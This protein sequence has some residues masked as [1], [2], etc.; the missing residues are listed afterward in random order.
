LSL[1]NPPDDSSLGSLFKLPELRYLAAFSF[2]YFS[3]HQKR[4]FV[5]DQPV[6]MFQTGRFV[7]SLA[8]AGLVRFDQ[9][10]G[11]MEPDTA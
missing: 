1:S 6:H 4:N 10:V 11:V 8:M 3:K 5:P 2:A 9:A 7:G